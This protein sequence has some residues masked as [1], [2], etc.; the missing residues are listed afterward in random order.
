MSQY[1]YLIPEAEKILCRYDIGEFESSRDLM[2]KHLDKA[3]NEHDS[4][5]V[6]YW[7][8]FDLHHFDLHA[9]E[10]LSA[11]NIVLT[12]VNDCFLF[13]FEKVRI[14]ETLK[15]Y[16]E[17]LSAINNLEQERKRSYLLLCLKAYILTVAERVTDAEIVLEMLRKKVNADGDPLDQD[18]FFETSAYMEAWCDNIEGLLLR[19]HEKYDEAIAIYEKG[20]KKFPNNAKIL[21]NLGFTLRR[22]KREPESVKAYEKAIGLNPNHI[23]TL[24]NAGSLYLQQGEVQKALA[25]FDKAIKINPFYD[26][27]LFHKGKFL[28]KSKESGKKVQEHALM[29][30]RQAHILNNRGREDVCIELAKCLFEDFG[31]KDESWS[32]VSEFIENNFITRAAWIEFSNLA[33]QL[34]VE[35]EFEHLEASHWANKLPSLNSLAF[36]VGQTRKEIVNDVD[37]I[38]E[39]IEKAEEALKS[40]IT[41]QKGALGADSNTAFWG[42]RMWNSFSPILPSSTGGGYFLFHEGRGT[43]IDPG[44]NF[45]HNF[46]KAGGHFSNINNVVV[47]HAHN[48][49][50]NDL[51]SILTLAF[52]RYKHFKAEQNKRSEAEQKEFV[53]LDLYLNLGTLK[54]YSGIIDLKESPYIRDIKVIHAEQKYERLANGMIMTVLP[55]YHDELISTDYAVGLCF[56]ITISKEKGKK[57]KRR[58]LLTSDTGLFPK[59]NKKSQ[60]AVNVRMPQIWEWYKEILPD[61]PIDLLIPHLGSLKREEINVTFNENLR[62]FKDLKAFSRIFYPNHL[63]I[64]GTVQLIHC[65]SPKV[66]LISEFGEELKPVMNEILSYIQ[67]SVERSF[68]PQ[69]APNV[70]ACTAQFKYD[71]VTNTVP[72][73]VGQSGP[74]GDMC[75]S[76]EGDDCTYK[77]KS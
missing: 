49:H 11:I 44:F 26:R 51:E 12:V 39:R 20:L 9:H 28:R 13:W 65:L 40:F 8:A 10:A 24:N 61:I 46:K 74:I 37:K 38:L 17:A 53:G 48:D 50:T 56:D 27:P 3:V 34:G 63:G 5:L 35:S 58:I 4:L 21:S 67:K 77:L 6:T 55:A 47:T 75:S 54:K 57:F 14:L 29:C 19:R 32:I 23:L 18:Y 66:A 36:I 52:I 25:H 43:V 69:K 60:L 1:D 72:D 71:L 42:L 62:S 33:K 7:K 68:A 16:D 59:S 2:Q 76:F 15:E 30:L 64:L 31:E 45:I 22:R 41:G 73:S 70:L